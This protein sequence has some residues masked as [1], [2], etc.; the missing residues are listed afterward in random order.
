MNTK[1][2]MKQ[3]LNE[4]VGA[5]RIMIEPEEFS[6]AAKEL[7]ELLRSVPLPGNWNSFYEGSINS[8]ERTFNSIKTMLVH[9]SEYRKKGSRDKRYYK[10]A[11]NFTLTR[12][13]LETIRLIIFKSDLPNYYMPRK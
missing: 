5:L 11:L 1:N 7:L 12:D 2:S 9:Y 8:W 4:K 10:P 3:A 13:L 6:A